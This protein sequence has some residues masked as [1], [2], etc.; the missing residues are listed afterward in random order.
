MKN[1]ASTQ[2]QEWSTRALEAA[3]VPAGGASI[4]AR[5]LVQTNLWGIDS[6]GISRLPHY[7]RRIEAG[8]V[9]A[10]PQMQ[11]SRTASAT[12]RVDADQ[13]LGILACDF[14]TDKAIEIAAEAGVAVVGI[15]NSSH[16]GAMSLY[17]RRLAAN[18]L[19]GIGFTHS[20]SFVVPYGGK[21]RFFGTNPIAI[22][23]PTQDPERPICVDAATSTVAW[24]RIMM[25]RLAGETVPLGWGVDAAGEPSTD[26]NVIEAVTPMSG[27]KGYAL[28]FLI[29]MLSGPLNG[30]PF[31]P[32]VPRMY[33]NLDQPRNLGALIIAI[34]PA[35]FGGRDFLAAMATQCATEVKQ[36]GESVM[37]PG[38]PEYIRAAER[39]AAGIPMDE[40]LVK[41]LNTCAE[42]LGIAPLDSDSV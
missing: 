30:M 31:G 39:L 32:H 5:A 17:V 12:G 19:A 2:L 10:A 14:A 9:K 3:G 25:A 42:R 4:V 27:H 26:P 20:D 13:A 41:E 33:E 35:R 22:A 21:Q 18:G 7:L 16:C 23:V 1:F 36:Q 24:N 28:A 38:E 37:Y 6:H 29:D 15:G 11:W 34:D 40:E 8:S